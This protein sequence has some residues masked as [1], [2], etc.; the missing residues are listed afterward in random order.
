MSGHND[1]DGD[2]PHDKTAATSIR[3]GQ[4]AEAPTGQR[5]GGAPASDYGPPARPQDDRD[6][7]PCAVGGHERCG[8]RRATA[9][10]AASPLPPPPP[11]PP[12]PKRQLRTQ[13]QNDDCDNNHDS[14]D[15]TTISGGLAGNNYG[16]AVRLVWEFASLPGTVMLF[17]VSVMSG[18]R[19]WKQQSSAFTFGVSMLTLG[20]VSRHVKCCWLDCGIDGASALI[21]GNQ[22]HFVARDWIPG[23]GSM[24]ALLN[25]DTEAEGAPAF[26]VKL[27]C[28]DDTTD[29]IL[30]FRASSPSSPPGAAAAAEPTK[31]VGT[32]RFGRD[33]ERVGQINE[34]LYCVTHL[35]NTLT[36]WDCNNPARPMRI[37]DH[38]PCCGLVFGHSGFLFHVRSNSITVTP[39][40]D[41]NKDDDYPG[42]AL[43]PPDRGTTKI[44][45]L[46]PCG[47]RNH[48][49]ITSL[50]SFLL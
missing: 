27:E 43:P 14:C 3:G 44:A 33:E 21:G 23:S 17:S 46:L 25:G 22:T 13:T 9:D 48:H 35:P 32:A 47:R 30:Q 8:W 2:D 31:P 26:V 37:V 12:R 41:D 38:A 45:I 19:Q 15:A 11:P 29:F 49:R 16:L 18:P 5:G 40:Y 28:N 20:I 39:A 7:P 42:D 34:R 4:T 6:V 50:F 10:D 1:A 24:A 36:I